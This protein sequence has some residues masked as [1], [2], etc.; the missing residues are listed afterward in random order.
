M[1]DGLDFGTFACDRAANALGCIDGV[2]SDGFECSGGTYTTGDTCTE[3]CGDGYHYSQECDDGNYYDD[4]GCSAECELEDGFYYADISGTYASD[5]AQEFTEE[6]DG[7]DYGYLECD[8]G[9][10]GCEGCIN[11]EV[12]DGYRCQTADIP[13]DGSTCTEICGDSF[14]YAEDTQC[15][16][17]NLRSGDGCSKT[18]SIETGYACDFTT[19][20]VADDCYEICGDGL[21]YARL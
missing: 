17:G 18:C 6:C 12:V 19:S 3:V 7:N 21:D 8:C 10:T 1:M 2:V 16:D 15:D 4:D 9:L 14:N 13:S 11:C 20:G 5:V